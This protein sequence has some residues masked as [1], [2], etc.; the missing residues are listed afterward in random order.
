MSPFLLLVTGPAGAGKTTAAAAWAASQQQPT[1]HFSLD[2][3]RDFVKSGYANPEDGWTAEA[4]RQYE[5]ARTACCTLAR[6]YITAGFNCV[7][8]DV[9]FPR[10]QQV[11]YEA[12]RPDLEGIPHQMV[13]LLPDFA[14]LPDRNR[15]RRGHR[16]LTVK[17][18]RTI[19]DMMLPWR[20][21][22]EFAVINTSDMS[23]EETV[24]VIQSQVD[25]A[26]KRRDETAQIVSNRG[27]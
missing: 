9:I 8:D 21:Q 4:Q 24:Q 11:S 19:Y 5:L 26:G 27:P 17:T 10:W 13:V 14:G 3:V 15:G 20:E 22:D 16:E 12:W 18:L 23:I 1:V 2:D 7:V 6:L 25:Q